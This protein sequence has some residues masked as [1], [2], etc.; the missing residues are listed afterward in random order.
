MLHGREKNRLIT[1]YRILDP[2]CIFCLFFFLL[3]AEGGGIDLLRKKEQSCYKRKDKKE[4]KR[5]G[6]RTDFLYGEEWSCYVGKR[7]YL[8]AQEE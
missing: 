4:E 1:W 2:F 3:G 5:R 7:E 6:E 8:I